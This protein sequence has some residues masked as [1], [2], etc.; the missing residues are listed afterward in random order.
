MPPRQPVPMDVGTRTRMIPKLAQ[1]QTILVRLDNALPLFYRMF[2]AED[3]TRELIRT[4]G[5]RLVRFLHTW[6]S[7]D[8]I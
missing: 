3:I 5:Y 4:V 2:G 8:C 1:A 7:I 6:L